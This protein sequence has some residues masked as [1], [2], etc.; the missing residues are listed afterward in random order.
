MDISG[1]NVT[2]Y[3]ECCPQIQPK[4]PNRCFCLTLATMALLMIKITIWKSKG[5]ATPNCWV[6]SGSSSL[7]SSH[8]GLCDFFIVQTLNTG[9]ILCIFWKHHYGTNCN[10]FCLPWN[11]FSWG[12]DAREGKVLF[13]SA[14]VWKSC[15]IMYVPAQCQLVQKIQAWTV[16]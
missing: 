16:I 11:C 2:G 15:P 10:V 8:I 9:W 7:P 13:Y 14:C 5:L 3:W 1:H 4:V 12:I 6:Q